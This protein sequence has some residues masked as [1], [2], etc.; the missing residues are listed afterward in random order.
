MK[1]QYNPLS[2]EPLTAAPADDNIT[3]DL[4]SKHIY[5][6]GVDFVGMDTTY[7]VFKKPTSSSDSGEVGLVPVPTY[8]TTAIRYLREDGTWATP[9]DT[10][11]YRPI[12]VDGTLIL[13]NNN[14][15]LNLVAGNNILLTPEMSGSSYTG[16]VT[17]AVPSLNATDDD[18]VILTPQNDNFGY[19]VKHAKKG[20]ESGYTSGNTTTSISGYGAS[21]T[22]LIPQIKVDE[23]GHVTE[24]YDE[25]VTITMPS[26]QSLNN[27]KVKQTA[28][29]SPTASG[30]ATAFIDSIS[31]NENG[32]IVVTKKNIIAQDLG[33]TNAMI[34]IGKTS[35]TLSDGA[36]T[37][38]ITIN[39]ENVTVKQGNVV[40][41]SS[42]KKEYIW[43]GSNW[44]EFGNEGNYKV[45]QS[46]VNDPTASGE[47]LTF[48]SNIAQDTNGNITT[49]NK[50][51]VTLASNTSAGIVPKV[52][53]AAGTIDSQTS[54]LV[55]S[56]DGSSVNW[57]KLPTT[58]FSDEN[59]TYTDGTGL[60]LNGTT[61][62]HT[63]AVTAKTA[64]ASTATTASANGGKIVLRDFKYDS[65]GHI[66][67]TTDRT[68]TLSEQ[69][70]GT[71][72]SVGMTV[73]TGL[74][75]SPTSINSSGTFAVTY[76]EGYS[77]PTNAK[78]SN[79]D[80]A[81]SWGNHADAGYTSNTGTVTSVGLSM[82]TS[83]FSITNSPVTTS[84]TLT[85]SFVTQSPNSIFAGPASGTGKA[86]P[87]FRAMV[88]ADHY[89]P[90]GGTAL[91]SSGN[92][93]SGSF[94]AVTSL[95]KDTKGHITAAELKTVT[96]PSFT[97]TWRTIQVEGTSIGN[98]TLNLKAGSQVILSSTN[99]IVTISSYD[100]KVQQQATNINVARP[101]LLGTSTTQTVTSAVSYDSNVT[102][103][104]STN[105]LAIP[106]GTVNTS[107]LQLESNEH[108]HTI[109]GNSEGMLIIEGSEGII[110][111][112]SVTCN[113][114]IKLTDG[115]YALTTATSSTYGLGT[116][117]QVLTSNG[118]DVYWSTLNYVTAD[119]LNDYAKKSDLAGFITMD[120]LEYYAT[121]TYVDQK[122]ST[123]LANYAKKTDLSGFITAS[124]LEYYATISYVDQ[125]IA[126]I[127]GGTV[128]SWGTTSNNTS[129]LTVAGTTKTVS[130][131]GHT[132]SNYYSSST[133]RTKNYV[134]AAPSTANG[135]AT[136][137]ALTVS[138]LPNITNGSGNSA[139][140]VMYRGGDN[141][142]YACAGIIIDSDDK[143][144][145]P[146]TTNTGSLGKSDVRWNTIY[147]NT[148]HAST[149]FYQ[150][151]DRNLKDNIQ[152]LQQDILDKIYNTNE[153]TFTWKST[154]ERAYGYIAQDMQSISED[155]IR[156]ENDGHLVLD[157]NSVLVLQV[158][159]LK[160]KIANLEERIQKL[161]RSSN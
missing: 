124:A 119:T 86:A 96:L 45:V 115:L 87:T 99:G 157:Y 16:K 104:P 75:V 133:S 110:L 130:L 18:V 98:N 12:K 127:K 32:E 147:G 120:A 103:N 7:N 91:T 161:E 79:W 54:D 44:E 158:A 159:A 68:I 27:Y 61:F 43:N 106:D 94:T 14:T 56:W 69:Y 53:T 142:P 28:V 88:L 112:N 71:V 29:S 83:V 48:I 35:T 138:D 36:T 63:N 126:G 156:V 15:A 31:Q 55:L 49:L 155:L 114:S 11:Y 57:Y 30:T 80:T 59:T 152:L 23:Y 64:F 141:K 146:L 77:I 143:V 50:K 108:L 42:N 4:P 66:T 51:T 128:V 116:S 33:L 100:E 89:T 52:G 151:S 122:I 97:D 1:F 95:T 26:E 73:P 41:D 93:T 22:I 24:A 40:I 67:E 84:G 5:V 85:A 19:D 81:Y 136:F 132:H 102:L 6:K 117:G 20:P 78:Q 60:T 92:V 101:L 139:R 17:I 137:R 153:V 109:E 38:P 144:L 121:Q 105:F 9:L 58:A 46:A 131:S 47:S 145:Y 37:N 2:A 129:P 90:T 72:T 10:N 76:A 140:A 25:T 34:Y 148:I 13:G 125:A 134:L 21:K 39:S 70:K 149:A 74:S 150:S 3:F 65:E 160:Q 111:D 135:A 154:G 62:N 113:H 123:E 107:I 82:P 8:T 118:S